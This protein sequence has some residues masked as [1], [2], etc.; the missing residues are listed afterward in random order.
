MRVVAAGLAALAAV[1]G[2]A[3]SNPAQSEGETGEICFREAAAVEHELKIPD[4]LLGAIALA[5]TGR[6]DADRRAS[7]AW[8][9]TVMAEGQ[10]RYFANKKDAVAE[11]KRLLKR[12][13]RNVDVGCMQ[14]NL[15]YHGGA[16]A[17][18]EE[19]LDPAAN[20]AY[21]GEYLRN[22]FAAAKSW[23]TAAAYYHS[24]TPEFSDAYKEKVVGLWKE[25]RRIAALA[26]EETA[27]SPA[28]PAAPAVPRRSVAAAAPTAPDRV[29]ALPRQ[30]TVSIDM[31]RTAELNARLRMARTDE[32]AV[33]FATRRTQQMAFWREARAASL[34]IDH[35]AVMRRAQA[36]A[37]RA[38]E[39]TA[40]PQTRAEA[41][42]ERRRDQ[43]RRWRDMHSGDDDT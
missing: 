15:Y 26:P 1:A 43:L 29:V 37:E 13:V 8:P 38:R 33:D 9:W 31:A 4:H 21:A 41:F 24:T 11:V 19:A 36:E 7:F 17:D 2:P 10:G 25:R 14:I 23:T 42:A 3:W 32:R 16:F 6:W 18:I 5:E 27:P 34:P 12:G 40:T 39:L 35:V 22:L 20:V 28:A 30:P